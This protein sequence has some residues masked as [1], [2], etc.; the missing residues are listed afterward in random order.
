MRFPSPISRPSF[1]AHSSARRWLCAALPLALAVAA[2]CA[3][4]QVPPPVPAPRAAPAVVPQA[5]PTPAA[6]ADPHPD[7]PYLPKPRAVP[8]DFLVEHP[9]VTPDA[10]PE[11][12]ALLHMLYQISGKHTLSGQHNDSGHPGAN[13]DVAAQITGKSPAVYGE[14]WGFGADAAARRHDEVKEL[15][16]QWQ[17]GHIIALCWHEPPPTMDEPVSFKGE[18][19]SRITDRQ[20]NDLLTPGTPLYKHWCTQLDAIAECLKELQDA[21]V[22]VLWR[23]LHE[24]NGDWFWWNGVRG[25]AAHGTKQLYRQEFDRLVHYH[26]LTNLVWVWNPDRPERADRQFVDY[27]PGSQYVDVLALDCYNVYKQSYYDELNALS[28]GK[29]LAIAETYVPPTL[30]VY[31]AQPKW[32]YYMRWSPNTRQLQRMLA[33]HQEQQAADT[34]A[35]ILMHSDQ[36]TPPNALSGAQLRAILDSPRLMSVSDKEYA[37]A[38]APVRTAAGQPPLR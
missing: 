9:P 26:H 18:I 4:A 31:K 36:P 21:H 29:P 30:E 14:D 13:T 22:P 5:A 15:I 8:A 34:F 11:A 23:P 7:I 35:G 17:A 33:S 25:D 20:F 27:F 37:Q 16:T 12:R 1:P 24:I 2:S 32:A 28:D 3:S 10:S 38:L 6:W 19:Q